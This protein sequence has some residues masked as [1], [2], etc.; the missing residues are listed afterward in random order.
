VSAGSFGEAN[1][2]DDAPISRAMVRRYVYSED[3]PGRRS[4][5]KLMTRDEAI[6][7]ATN[8]AKSVTEKRRFPAAN[9]QPVKHGR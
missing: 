7:I 3:E 6:R 2:N 9:R 1:S 4:V 5:A 8:I